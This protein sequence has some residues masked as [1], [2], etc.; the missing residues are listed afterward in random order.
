[1]T[2]PAA[3]GS[4]T[5]RGGSKRRIPCSPLTPNS[6]ALRPVPGIVDYLA[7]TVNDPPLFRVTPR[8][9]G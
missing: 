4:C 3:S 2:W 9:M 8:A 6:A 5:G 1:M 7:F